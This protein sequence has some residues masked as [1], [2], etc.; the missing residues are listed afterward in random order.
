MLIGLTGFAGS[1]KDEVARILVREHG[2]KRV[3][4]ADPLREMLYALNPIIDAGRMLRVQDLV[5]RLGWDDAKRQY[6]EIRQLLQRLGNEAAKPVFGDDCWARI[7][8]EAAGRT[9]L[10]TVFSDARFLVEAEQIRARGGQI[11]QINRPGVGPVNS[12]ASDAGLPRE[13]ISLIIN[14]NDTLAGLGDAVFK[15]MQRV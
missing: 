12:H 2:F 8:M 9:S 14:N 3:A 6:T 4:F 11:W 15:A 13:L 5:S 1:G 7:A 10:S